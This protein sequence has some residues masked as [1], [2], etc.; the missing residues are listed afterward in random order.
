MQHLVVT[1][2]QAVGDEP[3]VS[4]E[5]LAEV[6]GFDR[7][8]KIRELIERHLQALERFGSVCPTVG[9]T[10][11]KGGRPGKAYRLNRR[12]ALYLCTKSEAPLAT[13]ATIEMVEVF[14]AWQKGQLVA[15]ERSE[16]P[17]GIM[18]MRLGRARIL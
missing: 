2:I 5:R 10:S 16:L 17:S 6:L 14:D 8:R 1:D 12:Q 15:L 4:D 3:R 7:P 18:H 13:E 9:Q 11:A